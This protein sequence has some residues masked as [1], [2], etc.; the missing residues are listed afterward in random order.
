MLHRV[1]AEKLRLARRRVMLRRAHIA[2]RQTY[3]SARLPSCIGLPKGPQGNDHSAQF[4]VL[5]SVGEQVFE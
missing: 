4:V 1:C 3:C 5:R 2:L